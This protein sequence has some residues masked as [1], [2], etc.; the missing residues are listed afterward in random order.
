M[1]SID[2]L[3]AYVRLTRSILVSEQEIWLNSTVAQD[4]QKELR[5][6]LRKH[7]AGVKLLLAWSDC[8]TC[9]SPGLHRPYYYHAGL[10]MYRCAL[11][12]QLKAVC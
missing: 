4:L 12:E 10:Q 1:M 7:R 6:G 3:L 8:S 11:C 5:R 2:R 9:P